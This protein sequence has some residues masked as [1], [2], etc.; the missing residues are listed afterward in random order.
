MRI[1]R[2]L[3]L[4]AVGLAAS[5]AAVSGC[6]DTAKH[7]VHVRPPA[8]TPQPQSAANS[9]NSF[10]V[11]GL[12]IP[13]NAEQ[14]SQLITRPQTAVDVLLAEAQARFDAGQQAYQAGQPDVARKDFNAAAHMLM[15]S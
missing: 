1:R 7:A 15:N 5:L 14:Y 2:K 11:Q 8:A 6:Q 12:P 13:H 10:S 3:M 4:A 9:T